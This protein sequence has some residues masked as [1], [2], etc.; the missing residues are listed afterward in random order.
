LEE[1]SLIKDKKS[2]SK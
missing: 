2:K 1:V